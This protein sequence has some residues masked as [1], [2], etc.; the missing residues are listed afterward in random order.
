MLRSLSCCMAILICLVRRW[1]KNKHHLMRFLYYWGEHE[2]LIELTGIFLSCKSATLIETINKIQKTGKRI[3]AMWIIKI[4]EEWR[5]KVAHTPEW[6]RPVGAD[7]PSVCVLINA[8]AGCT[9]VHNSSSVRLPRTES[10]CSRLDQRQ[11]PW[12]PGTT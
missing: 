6:W 10:H 12:S 9:E 8:A 5:C 4:K 11:N 1:I 3:D 7:P 2:L